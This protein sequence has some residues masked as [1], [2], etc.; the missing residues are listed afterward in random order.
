MLLTPVTADIIAALITTGELP[1]I[2]EPFA[3]T[4]FHHSIERVS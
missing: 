3:V 1:E 4:R 2:A